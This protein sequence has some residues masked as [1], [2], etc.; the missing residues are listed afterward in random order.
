MAVA[1]EVATA[2][3]GTQV[4]DLEVAWPP[5]S[6]PACGWL[7]LRAPRAR[8][9]PSSL[10]L[11]SPLVPMRA[12]VWVCALCAKQGGFAAQKLLGQKA[13]T[14]TTATALYAR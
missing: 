4:P 14:A 8:G 1:G 13:S 9:R 12:R 7:V 11:H 2:V 5:R 6:Q 10:S 3:S